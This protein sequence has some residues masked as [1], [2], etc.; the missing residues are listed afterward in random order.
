LRAIQPYGVDAMEM[1]VSLVGFAMLG[2]VS[3]YMIRKLRLENAA[4][5]T[6][7]AKQVA[8]LWAK[9]EA[10]R[11]IDEARVKR[12]AKPRVRKAKS[13]AVNGVDATA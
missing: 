2:S 9:V 3:G 6:E 7:T 12:T 11:V 4:L 5:R 8:D 10:Y 13:Q 1:I